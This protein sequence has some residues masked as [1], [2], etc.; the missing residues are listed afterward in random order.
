MLGS[1]RHAYLL[2]S[3]LLLVLVQPFLGERLLGLALIDVFLIVTLV[4]SIVT[5]STTRRQLVIGIAL[6]A[7][8][9][10]AR[11]SAL[12]SDHRVLLSS[13]P[14]LGLLFFVYV[15]AL[16]LHEVFRKT[17]EVSADTIAGALSVYLLLGLAWSFAYALLEI[18]EPG[19]F[20]FGGA[21]PDPTGPDFARFLGF[22]FVT[23]TTL[24]YGNIVP[25]NPRADALTST[26]ALVG[27]IY[28][29]VLVAR[30]IAIQLQQA[31]SRRT[32]ERATNEDSTEE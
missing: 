31:Y 4:T 10:M 2:G 15:T 24:G 1:Y 29:A 14:G 19:S 23:L 26:E 28:L 16:M 32:G 5:C 30:L 9:E 12:I 22:S 18:A 3:L 8:L 13:A 7:A 6:A 25:T 11:W 20:S 21:G 27:Q 17:R